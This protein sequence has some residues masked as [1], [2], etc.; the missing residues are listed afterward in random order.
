[1][2]GLAFATTT[3]T[4][5]KI[6]TTGYIN[7]STWL[8]VTDLKT[9][10]LVATNLESNLDGTGFN[11]TA[12][13]IGINT[14]TPNMTIDMRYNSLGIGPSIGF[15]YSPTQMAALA[16]SQNTFYFNVHDAAKISFGNSSSYSLTSAP[17]EWFNFTSSGIHANNVN[18]TAD[19]FKLETSTA[20][21][22][23]VVLGDID[24]G[25]SKNYATIRGLIKSATADVEDGQINFRTLVNGTMRTIL[26]VYGNSDDGATLDTSVDLGFDNSANVFFGGTDTDDQAATGNFTIFGHAGGSPSTGA[27]FAGGNVYVTAG[28]GSDAEDGDSNGGDG[29][30]IYIYGGKGGA[31]AGAGSTGTAGN[32]V[33]GYDGSVTKGVVQISA[34]TTV[35]TCNAGNAGAIYYDG[36][37]NKHYGCNVTD[38]QA[39]Y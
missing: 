3:I 4:D 37:A 32:L 13:F 5:S 31:L 26:Q 36:N 30:N 1:M 34:N 6:E 12:D 27:G 8:N 28:E 24:F 35:A 16:L 23:D 19:S 7:V 14:T 21:N 18:I 25:V 33:L 22:D 38:W 2:A 17:T 11:I 20:Y 29:G 39:M 15:W 10:N 9:T